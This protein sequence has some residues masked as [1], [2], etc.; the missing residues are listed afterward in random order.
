MASGGAFAGLA[1]L[2]SASCCILPLALVNLGVGSAL[3]TNLSELA[4][5]RPWLIGLTVALVGV[6]LAVVVR[7]GR[8]PTRMVSGLFSV[9]ALLAVAAIIVPTFESNI[10]TWLDL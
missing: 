3:A 9:A 1:A 6:G 7:R 5:F 8:R 10:L 2:L 4:P